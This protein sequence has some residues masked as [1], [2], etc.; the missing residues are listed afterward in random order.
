M[1]EISES[2]LRQE[3]VEIAL[4]QMPSPQPDAAT[5]SLLSQ[6]DFGSDTQGVG[7]KAV[8]DGSALP[9]LGPLQKFNSWESLGS[10][11]AHK[12]V[13]LSSFNPGAET[14]D[15]TAW[16]NY[17]LKFSTLPFFLTY[18]SD[19]RTVSISKVSLTKA[20]EAVS[21]LVQNIMTP[22]NFQ[23]IVTTIKKI[24]QLA[25]EN[26]GQVQT[27]SNQ[28]VGVLSRKSGQ[29]YLGAV[30]TAVRM[31]YNTGKRGKEQLQ[32]NL[33]VYRGYGVLD[34]DKCKRHAD[35]LIRW[36]EEDVWEWENGTASA[37]K[38]PNGSPAWNN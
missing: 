33:Q 36:D 20:V 5:M 9:D 6:L 35:T 17:L 8:G 38:P 32:Q 3:A 14:F 24:A 26:K 30:R 16:A 19:Y 22:D 28:Q 7:N 31:E 34:F 29:L 10:T 13:T 27:N 21:D 37:P 25:L 12:A 15:P 4:W 23:G 11:L 18:T 1:T 2:Q